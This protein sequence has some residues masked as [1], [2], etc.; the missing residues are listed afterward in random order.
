MAAPDRR[1]STGIDRR[2]SMRTSIGHRDSQAE[3]DDYDLEAMGISDGFRPSNSETS[4]YNRSM[5]QTSDIRVPP[6]RPSSTTKPIAIDSFA[7]RHD[8]A[9]GT[10]LRRG[11]TSA[12]GASSA[13]RENTV[14]TRASSVSTDIGYLRPESPYR[15]PTGPSHP[16]QMYP[17]ES[18]LA[19]TA[20]M[21]TTTTVPVSERSY[22]GP[23][24]PTHP[25]GMY[26]QNIVEGDNGE[27]SSQTPAPPIPVGFPGQNNNCQRRLGSDGEEIADIIGP[28][29]HTEQLPPYTQYPDVAFARKP[30]PAVAVTVSDT[31]QSSIPPAPSVP[32]AG[33]IGLATRNPEFASQENL[34]SPASRR[35]IMSDDVS[36]HQINTAATRDAEK[37]ELK[38]WQKAA[39]RKVWGIIPVW[40]F[41]LTAIV[42]I[43]FG[44]VLGT[45]L[46]I[47]NPKHSK[48]HGKK[49]P[50]DN[51]VPAESVFYTP[52]MTTTYD[53]T[54]LTTVPTSIPALPTGNFVL[55]ISSPSLNQATCLQNTAQS[56]AWSCNIAM[57]PGPLQ[58]IIDANVSSGPLENNEMI[59]NYGDQTMNS[60]AYGAQA[61]TF[62]QEQVLRLVRDAD[63]VARGPAW[64][65]QMA[66]DKIVVIR[67]TD[68]A[69]SSTRK[70]DG[71][72]GGRPEVGDF[73]RKGV[74]Q[75]GEK[76]WFCFWNGTVLEAFIYPNQTSAYGSKMASQ[77]AL[78]TTSSYGTGTVTGS[79]SVPTSSGGS[80]VQSSGQPYWNS[81]QPPLIP[82]YGK[83]V[84]I[85]EHRMSSGPQVVPPYCVQ[86]SIK[87]D[88]TASPILNSAKQP[89]TVYLNETEATTFTKRGFLDLEER[90]AALTK[91]EDGGGNKCGCVW[92]YS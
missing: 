12:S 69:P 83:V 2:S 40:V 80:G 26:P 55:P 58:I 45:V 51:D 34:N 77:A 10:D 22:A 52:V 73:G 43:L 87:S 86:N 15:G 35:S 75:P 8:G 56:N 36:S 19:R 82:P 24:G 9:M 6:P 42:F 1:T 46:A 57:A 88:G 65:F 16:Y 28:D 91:R 39:R 89:V 54:P 60:F 53:A 18:R 27:S 62:T 33:G 68:L 7:L 11:S 85:E 70:R 25:Y 44:I 71:E 32:G 64:W 78:T 79:S 81:Y 47:I 92:L 61:P 38:R 30:R 21:A 13:S 4:G 14:P 23:S 84:K 31:A 72:S 63:E 59:L 41:F 17:Q 37:P 29:G 20:S 74:A 76:P 3:D 90:D 49:Y 50:N 5:N 67:E 66:Y 48:G